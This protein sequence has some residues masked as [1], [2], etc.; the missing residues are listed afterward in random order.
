MQLSL[1]SRTRLGV[2]L[3]VGF[4]LVL[5]LTAVVG[6]LAIRGV[7][8]VAGLTSNLYEHP[9]AVTRG[10]LTARAD[11]RAVQRAMA[12]AMLARDAAELDRAVADLEAR[13]K[14]ALAALGEA[15]G[16]FLGDKAQ[17]D[18]VQQGMTQYLEVARQVVAQ[19]RQGQRTEAMA[20]YRGSAIQAQQALAARWGPVIDFAA[21]KAAA[22]MQNATV[23]RDRVITLNLLLIGGAVVLGVL[24]SWLVTRSITHPVA[25]LRGCMAALAKGDHATSVPGLDRRDEI[26]AMAQAVEVFRQNAAEMERLRAAQETQKRQVAEER[27]LALRK[28]AD[29]FEAQVGSVLNAVTSAAT[30][31]QAAAN[32]MTGNAGAT[33]EQATT[34]ATTSQQASA[35]VQTVASAT[36]ELAASITEIGGQVERSRTVAER[37]DAEATQTTQLIQRLSESVSSIGAIV[38]L[39]N[40]IANQTNLLALNAT[41]EAAR[42][43]DAGKGF[44]VVAGEVKGLAGQTAKATSEIAAQIAS[45]QAGTADAVSAITSITK[46]M[47]EMSA[48]SAAVAA[49][50]QEQTAAT[51]E[52]ARNVEQAAAGTA[53][54]SSRIAKVENA[55]RETGQ[56]AQQIDSSATELS[57]Q[58]DRLRQ[59][60]ARFLDG[61]RADQHHLRLLCWDE[62]LA[63]GVREIDD[64]HR[65]M[66]DQLNTFFA[67][68]MRGEGEKA[69]TRVIASLGAALQRHLV[70]E[71]RLMRDSGYAGLAAHQASHQDFLQRFATLRRDVEAGIP[72]AVQALFDQFSD[73]ITQHIRNEDFAFVRTLRMKQAA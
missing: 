23:T 30:Q 25:G 14:T 24:L 45:V 34:V 72:G 13:G 66:F 57:R 5:L 62:S 49:A 32:Q 33:T 67:D 46:V 69:A 11:M 44:A 54:V 60:V 58:A 56:A 6:G 59:E 42:A 22:F 68:M 18:A 36:E 16:R 19:L 47:A 55:A 9:F 7:S 4:A 64:H 28:L 31:L 63:C 26:G 2:R 48:I 53:D 41:I 61:V 37:A 20:A 51:G 21:A 71:E 52:I 70:D 38:A 65:A 27:R 43:G 12:D 17:F 35:N 40:N 15:H 3:G 50:V 39:I 8:A 29:G 1:I 10:L 73:W